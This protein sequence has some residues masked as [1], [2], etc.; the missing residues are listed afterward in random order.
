MNRRDVFRELCYKKGFVVEHRTLGEIPY[1]SMYE[2]YSKKGPATHLALR[3]ESN[4]YESYFRAE[5]IED[6]GEIE[7]LVNRRAELLEEEAN[8]NYFAE[9]VERFRVHDGANIFG[10][11]VG[12]DGSVGTCT[13]S[14]SD[15]GAISTWENPNEET[16]IDDESMLFYS[17]RARRYMQ[18][19][20][21]IK[22]IEMLLI[23]AAEKRLPPPPQK[24]KLP[25]EKLGKVSMFGLDFL[26]VLEN[27]YIGRSDGAYFHVW[28]KFYI[29]NQAN[30]EYIEVN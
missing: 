21:I 29:S 14:V 16:V 19:R 17:R 25:V 24:T 26:F 22:K 15:D 11:Y 9:A 13:Y 27:R 4:C 3:P 6:L 18:R 8:D 5:R 10:E 12:I 2:S 23:Y 30:A 28:K 20:R 7:R 1:E